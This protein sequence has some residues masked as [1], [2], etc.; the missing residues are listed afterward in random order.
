MAL[1]QVA[2]PAYR[3]IDKNGVDLT[4]GTFNFDFLEGSIGKGD[5]ALELRTVILD[6]ST[7]NTLDNWSVMRAL[8]SGTGATRNVTIRIANTDDKF[9]GGSA[10]SAVGTGATLTETTINGRLGYIY[11]TQS[12]LTYKFAYP[13]VGTTG[14]TNLCDS[15]S[16]SSCNIPLWG[17]ASPTGMQINVAWTVG[18]A[19]ASETFGAYCTIF[20]RISNVTNTAGYKITPSYVLNTT[21]TSAVPSPDW[22]TKSSVQLSNTLVSAPSWP[23]ITYA[24]PSSGVRTVTTPGGAVWRTTST[25]G[26]IAIKRPGSSIDNLVVS[27]GTNGVTSVVNDGVTTTYSRSVAGSTATTV[28]SDS[29]GT[30]L[31]LVS[32]LTLSRPTSATDALGRVTTYA[33]DTQ[34]RLT[35]TVYPEGN[36]LLLAY[37]SRSNVIERRLVAKPGTSLPDIVTLASYPTTCADPSCNSPTWT[38][39]SYS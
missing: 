30:Q 9:I 28:V 32:D 29:L 37:D 24:Y 1:A 21:N 26:S 19:C 2:E 25:N 23:T 31:T 27:Y 22:W 14:P 16:S 39:P 6:N 12:G 7:D 38:S 18:R 4:S 3:T 17:I 36:K 34:A 10:T 33:Y 11:T 13:I 5:A 35:Q 15:T 20:F 8:V